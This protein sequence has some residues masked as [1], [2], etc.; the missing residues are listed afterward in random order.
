MT[1]F[2]NEMQIFL[3]QIAT[4]IP[5]KGTRTSVNMLRLKS[6]VL[7]GRRG[8]SFTTQNRLVYSDS[9]FIILYK[10]NLHSMHLKYAVKL[11]FLYIIKYIF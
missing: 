1:S 2:A 10:Q 3:W 9:S 6:E 11:N 5:I 7:F 4:V 8:E